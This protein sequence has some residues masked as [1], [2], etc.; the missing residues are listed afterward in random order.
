MAITPRTVVRNPLL[1]LFFSALAIAAIGL[2]FPCSQ[3][4]ACTKSKKA[5]VARTA[6]VNTVNMATMEAAESTS[7]FGWLGVEIQTLTPKR[8]EL[9]GVTAKRGVL[10]LGLMDGRPAEVAGFK[11]YDVIVRFNGKPMM[12]ACQ[13]Q[14]T[15]A[16]TKPGTKVPVHVIRD[17]RTFILHPRLADRAGPRGCGARCK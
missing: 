13:L 10:V 3:R 15:V 9:A 5:P 1:M 2:M 11:P 4:T 16:N 14:H 7:G 6:A 12:N 8:A 17:G